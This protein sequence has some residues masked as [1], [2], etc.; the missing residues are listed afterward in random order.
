[1]K[2]VRGRQIPYDFAY[3]WNPKN[4]TNEQ[5]SENRNI[6]METEN[7][8]CLPEGRVWGGDKAGETD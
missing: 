4:K 3:M 5:T 6:L 2:Q 7:K 8:R 1:M